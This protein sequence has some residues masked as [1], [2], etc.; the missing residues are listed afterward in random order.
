MLKVFLF[1][2]VSGTLYVFAYSYNHGVGVAVTVEL[3]EHI[4]INNISVSRVV[5]G[6]TGIDVEILYKS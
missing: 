3:T 4:L 5:S 1:H 2:L 6:D